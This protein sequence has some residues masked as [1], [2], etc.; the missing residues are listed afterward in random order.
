MNLMYA[1]WVP[2]AGMGGWFHHLVQAWGSPNAY[3]S[4]WPKPTPPDESAT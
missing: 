2:K 3:D 4:R 1:P